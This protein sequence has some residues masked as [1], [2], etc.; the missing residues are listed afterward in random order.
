MIDSIK[1]LIF[2]VA[3][4]VILMS[5]SNHNQ[6]NN[7]IVNQQ[8]G[9]NAKIVDGGL[10]FDGG[11]YTI[12][13][14]DGKTSDYLLYNSG[15]DTTL[16][17]IGKETKL[18]PYGVGDTFAFTPD[19]DMLVYTRSDLADYAFQKANRT[20]KYRYFSHARELTVVLKK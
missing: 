6:A 19:T 17:S 16:Y 1:N 20:E 13:S 14:T 2:P 7:D 3:I 18:K 8:Y 9:I 4:A 10:A 5:C 15:T 11:N 12:L